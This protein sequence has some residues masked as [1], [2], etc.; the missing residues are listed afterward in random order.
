MHVLQERRYLVILVAVEGTGGLHG[1]VSGI[2]SVAQ[3]VR[4]DE[5]ACR[6]AVI[7]APGITVDLL[8]G[9]WHGNRAPWRRFRLLVRRRRA[10]L[11]ARENRRPEIGPR[12]NFHAMRL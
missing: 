9:L 8:A 7:D 4:N 2:G 3:T 6:P 11:E 10:S 1:R 5:G 12:R